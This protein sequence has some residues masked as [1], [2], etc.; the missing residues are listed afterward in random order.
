MSKK[1]KPSKHGLNQKEW[2]RFKALADIAERSKYRVQVEKHSFFVYSGRI[3]IGSVDRTD[4]RFP[5]EHLNALS[6]LLRAL[7]V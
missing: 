7:I 3:A 2:E 4:G 6:S 1:S 5:T